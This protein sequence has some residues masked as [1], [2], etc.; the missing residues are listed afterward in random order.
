M[1]NGR[2][3]LATFAVLCI[4]APCVLDAALAANNSSND[5]TLRVYKWTDEQGVVHYGDSIPSQYAQSERD[6][7]NGQGVAIGHVAGR[8]SDAQEGAQAQAQRAAQQRAQRDQFLLATYASVQ[9]IEQLRDERLDQ[10]AGQIKASSIYIESLT[11]RLAAL[12]ERALHFSPYSG[13]P[14]CAPYAR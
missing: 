10:I 3:L 11:L 13:D 2:Q 14:E 8:K 6:V 9:E 1:L 4:A 12:E 5:P 7:L